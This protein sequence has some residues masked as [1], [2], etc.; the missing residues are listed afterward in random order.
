MLTRARYSAGDWLRGVRHHAGFAAPRLWSAGFSARDRFTCFGRTRS[1]LCISR[2]FPVR[3]CVLAR[4]ICPAGHA[5][6]RHTLRSPASGFGFPLW[7][8]S[9]AIFLPG[10]SP[11]FLVPVA[12]RCHRC[13]LSRHEHRVSWTVSRG[14][15]ATFVAALV[16]VLVWS[17]IGAMGEMIMGLKLHPLFSIPFALGVSALVPLLSHWSRSAL[18]LAGWRESAVFGCDRCR[19]RTGICTLVQCR[20]AATPQRHLRTGSVRMENGRSMRIA[21][22]HGDAHGGGIFGEAATGFRFGRAL[23]CRAGR[24]TAICAANSHGGRTPIRQRTREVTVDLHG[25]GGA[26]MYVTI[27]QSADLNP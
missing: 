18:P 16:A 15:A 19:R 3:S 7:V 17:S 6:L 26:Q 4:R 9:V 1:G 11:Y 21:P 27:P 25:S 8:L 2:R 13:C 14:L 5:I 22:C 23:L 12:C 10:F 20:G 24:R